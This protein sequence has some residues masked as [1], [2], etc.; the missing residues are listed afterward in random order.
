MDQENKKVNINLLPYSRNTSENNQRS[1]V[2]LFSR[3]GP[4]CPCTRSTWKRFRDLPPLLLL[5]Q[6]NNN[7]SHSTHV[8]IFRCPFSL[9]KTTRA[10]G[11]WAK[12]YLHSF[13]FPF[14]WSDPGD[15]KGR[16]RCP[17]LHSFSN[18]VI[19]MSAQTLF[20]T[21]R[22]MRRW[23]CN[24]VSWLLWFLSGTSVERS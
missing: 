8:T 21:V 2:A 1:E 4:G 10:E 14:K 17:G 7:L 13:F 6:N 18:R 16:C 9:S 20:S 24:Y 11:L 3:L 22:S 23:E 19:I 12:R 15:I 5:C